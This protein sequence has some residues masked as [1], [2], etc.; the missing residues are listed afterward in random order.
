M[1]GQLHL[2]EIN[3]SKLVFD[4]ESD[5]LHEVDDLAWEV[6]DALEW[7]Y[8]REDIYALLSTRYP[9]E[10]IREVTGEIEELKEKGKLWSPPGHPDF[11]Q[12]AAP[13]VK[14]LCLNVAHACNLTCRYCFAGKG[15]YRG[16]TSLM[17]AEVGKAAVDFLL[18]R[19]NGR[20]KAEID[21]FGGEP[22]LN[23][24]AVK[25]ITGYARSKGDAVGTE[26]RFTL[27]TN[28]LLLN[29]EVCSYLSREGFSV[30]LSLDGRP[31]VHDLMRSFPDGSASYSRVLERLKEFL[32]QWKGS[33]YVRGTFTRY[34]R[35]FFQ[36]VYHL[37]R[38]G[39]RNLSLEPAVADPDK[40]WALRE[41]D[42]KE[43]ERQY[44]ELAD[45]YL[46]C[47]RKGDP[48][49]FF[50]FEIDLEEGP[51]LYKRLSGCGAGSE[52]LAV[53]PAGDLYPCH[54]LVGRQEYCMGNVFYPDQVKE[55]LPPEVFPPVGP[56]REE[57]RDCWVRYHCGGGC[58]AASLEVN[59]DPAVPYRLECALQKTRLECALYIKANLKE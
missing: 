13:V 31:E 42:L 8:S 29:E 4:V 17:P 53:T 21:Y 39:F 34:N 6:I 26:F 47:Y 14:A 56:T 51:C 45:F 25:D 28:G 30:I 38:E 46:E 58:R 33:Y 27:T 37:Y 10:E 59:G 43:L 7:G 12:A 23:M 11:S 19:S 22:L 44:R 41:E 50:H 24:E 57:C 2:F 15:E 54:Q 18:Q 9:A 5:T 3:D 49:T 52:Y 40:D 36:D 55:E 35:D 1:S 16:Q 20:S 32:H 48:F